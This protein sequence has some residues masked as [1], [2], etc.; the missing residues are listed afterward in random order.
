[1][2]EKDLVDEHPDLVDLDPA[3]THLQNPNDLL[4]GIGPRKYFFFRK[5]I[6]ILPALVQ[7]HPYMQQEK[8]LAK[9]SCEGLIA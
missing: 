8:I 9:A 1:M 5:Y 3:V 7:N 4:A 6:S 2:G